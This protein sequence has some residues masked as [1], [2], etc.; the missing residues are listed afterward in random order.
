MSELDKASFQVEACCLRL[1][2]SQFSRSKELHLKPRASCTVLQEQRL[3]TEGGG[4]GNWNKAYHMPTAAG[5]QLAKSHHF[6]ANLN[7]C[8]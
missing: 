3:Q 4:V 2:W 6:A 5:K 8:R 1:R 7:V